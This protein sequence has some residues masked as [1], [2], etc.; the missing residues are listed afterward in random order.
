MLHVSRLQ[1]QASADPEFVESAIELAQTTFQS[2]VMATGAVYMIWHFV[3]TITWPSSYGPLVWAVT[4]ILVATSMLAWRFATRRILFAQATWQLGLV[5][6]ITLSLRLFDAP[7][8]AFF[9]ALLPLMATVTTNWQAGLVSEIAVVLLVWLQSPGGPAPIL[10]AAYLLAIPIG[11]L[12]TGLVGWSAARA[13]YTVTEWSFYSFEQARRH[14]AEV[15]EHRGR[16]ARAVRDLDQAYYRLER[17]NASLVAAWRAADEAERFKA[18]FVTNVSHELRTPLNLIVGFSE[19]MMTSPESYGDV[20]MPGAYRSDLS[21]VYHSAQHL[22]AL[23]DDVLDLAR[24]QSGRMA[25]VRERVDLRHLIAEA[26]EMV[27]DYVTAKGLALRVEV[28]ADLPAVWVDRLRIRQVILNLLV[29]AAR[30]TVEGALGV[31]AVC[32]EGQVMVRISDTG[33]GIPEGDLAKIFEAFRTTEQPLSAWHSGTGLGLPISKRFIELHHGMMGVDSVVDEGSTFWFTLPIGPVAAH[34]QPGA[35]QVAGP[36]ESRGMRQRL[37]VVVHEDARVATVIERHLGGFLTASAANMAE[38]VALAE[39]LKAVAIIADAQ[40]DLVGVE[41]ETPVIRCSLPSNLRTA[42]ALG[43]DELLIKPVSRERLVAAIQRLPQA[44]ERVLI[45]DDDPDVARL[46][47][48][49]LY[50]TID[51]DNCVEAFNGR[52]ALDMIA[53][54]APDLVILDLMM[55]EIDGRGVLEHMAANPEMRDIP[56]ILVTAR[57]D[58]GAAYQVPGSIEIARGTGFEIGEVISLLRATLTVLAPGWSA[59]TNDPTPP[60]AALG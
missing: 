28:A 17:A 20:Q 56:V 7:E 43:A 31:E 54:Q 45:A 27:S 41:C 33:R 40:A 34:Q 22:L 9:Y 48:R 35:L 30:F 18:E 29:N 2:L 55:P 49:M 11:G 3:A 50:G 46:F 16:L 21:A 12:L 36:G 60:A 47:R 1:G 39:A 52:E 5:A 32:D 59:E 44:V 8:I 26:I 25:I 4:P 19:M 23:V 51:P 42:V 37:A 6:G 24:I 58:D 38:G 10:P 57:G 15:R 53:M 13:L 14:V